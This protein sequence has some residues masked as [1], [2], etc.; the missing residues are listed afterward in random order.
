[1]VLSLWCFIHFMIKNK[2]KYLI[3]RKEIKMLVP[4]R[5]L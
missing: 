3:N 4:A 1:M 2:K 5:L